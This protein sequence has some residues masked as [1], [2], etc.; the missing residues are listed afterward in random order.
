MEVIDAVMSHPATRIPRNR[1]SQCG[2]GGDRRAPLGRAP[3]P[4]TIA[5]GVPGRCLL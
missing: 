3:A 2:A 1:W 5:V 4:D